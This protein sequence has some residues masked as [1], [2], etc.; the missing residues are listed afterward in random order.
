MDEA[1]ALLQPFNIKG[2]TLRNRVVSTS[3]APA[4]AEDGLPKLQ[5]R[6]YHEEKAKGGVAMTMFGGSSVVSPE[7]PAS[8]GQLDMSDDRIIPYLQELADAV[9]KHGAAT[10]CQISHMGRRSRWDAGDW[11]PNISPSPIR[12]PEHRSFPKQMEKWEIRQA[13]KDFGDAARRCEDGG[14]DGVQLSFANQH[15]V[16]QFW[17]PVSNRRTDNYG[18][19]LDNR[20][21]ISF[22]ILDEVRR[23]VSDDFVVGVRMNGDELVEG[24]LD[25]E[26]CLA[27]AVRLAESGQVDFLD[28]MGGVPTD[29]LSLAVQIG[30]MSFPA[31]QFLY[32]ASKIK[33]ETD[34]PVLQAQKIPDITTA[35]RAVSEGHIDLVGMVRAQ[36]ADPYLVQKLM[37]G[38]S[39]E[40]RQC[41]GANYCIDKIYIGGQALCIQNPAM[42]REDKMPHAIQRASQKRRVVIAGGGPA[43]LEAARVSAERGHA[44]TLIEKTHTLGGQI[45][46]AAKAPWRESL[47]GIS[48]WLQS[49][50]QTLEVD[51]RLGETATA[52]AILELDPDHVIIATGG[53]PNK[54]NFAGADLTTSTWDILNGAEDVSESV[55]VFDDH[56]GHQALSCAEFI[57]KRGATLEFVTPEARPGEEIGPT[58]LPIHLRELY[59]RDTIFSPNL[60]LIEVYRENGRLIAVLRNEF[61][62]EEEERVVDQIVS[63]HGTLPDETLYDELVHQSKNLGEV[64][65][66]SL[67]RGVL[68]HLEMNAGG[69]FFLYR[70]GDSVASR[71]IHAAIF[72]GLRYCKDL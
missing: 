17:S 62:H 44:V 59:S 50:V 39:D 10:M 65:K 13:V 24:G 22:E 20:L 11:L 43:G 46:T 41:V 3:H 34:I 63:E 40:I 26:E 6:L 48:R 53:T 27:I 28:V 7:C 38:Q 57:A 64:D 68:E 69:R 8:F 60:R 58:N 71:N 54:G 47:L 9:H 52:E 61:T 37:N 35:A 16:A 56:G 55:L 70:I 21:R 14:L 45:N 66:R 32:L 33:A 67:Q 2:L 19:S 30:N 29:L 15:L 42:G 31:A 23:S 1:R 18:G 49:R 12:E 72:D 36:M 4:Y 25:L 51:V 5:Y